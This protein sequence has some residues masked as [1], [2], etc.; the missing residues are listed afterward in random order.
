MNIRM[1]Q[2]STIVEAAIFLPV[3]LIALLTVA[4][5]IRVAQVQETM[6]NILTEAAGKLIVE[7]YAALWSEDESRELWG[8]I[9][10]C[11]AAKEVTF[12][13][14]S[15][16]QA[17]TQLGNWISDYRVAEF[18]SNQE[19][20]PWNHLH[21][22]GIGCRLRLPMADLFHQNI[23]IEENITCRG[24]VGAAAGGIP[25]SFSRMEREEDQSPVYV[26]PRDGE[27]YHKY[28]CRIIR[29]TPH[30]S[31]LTATIKKKLESCQLCHSGRLPLGT[32]VCCFDGGAYHRSS[33]S[34][35]TR[36][37]VCMEKEKAI[38]EGYASCLI[39]GG[40]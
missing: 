19:G 1:K 38:M 28:S 35:M 27:K 4:H 7:E 15:R 39:C 5:I 16:Q 14:R 34:V 36:Y 2:G 6:M 29:T 22:L 10:H 25:F 8:D 11:D 9:V 24:F 40:E 20:D 21:H 26:F 33:C 23:K 31:L 12:Y 3:F 37:V 30:R 17:E 13:T 18:E 32:P